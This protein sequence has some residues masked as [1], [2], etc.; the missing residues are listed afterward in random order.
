[1]R[2]YP[3]SS[4]PSHWYSSFL[5]SITY[6]LEEYLGSF[7]RKILGSFKGLPVVLQNM[8]HPWVRARLL[9]HVRQARWRDCLHCSHFSKAQ[10]LSQGSLWSLQQ[11]VKA[12]TQIIR[13]QS[14]FPLPHK[15]NRA[16]GGGNALCSPRTCAEVGK[17]SPGP[18]WVL[19]VLTLFLRLGSGFKI[20]FSFWG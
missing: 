2:N 6:T 1:M 12:G 11:S 15:E 8:L 17:L 9:P 10:Y 16:V 4:V 3:F 7:V 14:F 13:P 5:T 18:L 19:A 20:K